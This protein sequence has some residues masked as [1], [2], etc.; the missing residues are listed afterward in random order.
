MGEFNVPGRAFI[1]PTR[2]LNKEARG[3]ERLGGAKI[4]LGAPGQT[5]LTAG[6]RS[7]TDIIIIQIRCT[8][9]SAVDTLGLRFNGD[10]TASYWNHND[11]SSQ[12]NATFSNE[13]EISQT[14]IRLAITISGLTNNDDG[15]TQ[16]RFCFGWFNNTAGVEKIGQWFQCRAT[17][18]VATPGT[19]FFGTGSWVKTGQRITSVTLV[20]GGGVATMNAGTGF[21]VFGKDYP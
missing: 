18:A 4:P 17:N 6:L 10:N 21:S 1:D 3:V 19:L 7:S 15:G 2:D 13:N 20:T 8:G 5:S 9:L 14:S 12:G 16:S 11:V